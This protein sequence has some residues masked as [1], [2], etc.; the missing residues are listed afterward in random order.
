VRGTDN[1]MWHK[2]WNGQWS[3]WES[4]GGIL[5]TA[6]DCVSWSTNRID[7]FVVGTNNAVWH[8][9]WN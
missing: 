7:C 1:A 4:L 8:K 6:P 3:A 9:W 5:T 2:W